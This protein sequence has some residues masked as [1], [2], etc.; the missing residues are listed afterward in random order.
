MA[1]RRCRNFERAKAIVVRR[2][3]MWKANSRLAR[4]LAGSTDIRHRE[5]KPAG[6]VVAVTGDEV[7]A[8]AVAT[9]HDAEAVVLDLV[10]AGA[11]G[12]SLRRRGQTPLDEHQPGAGA[13]TQRHNDA[14]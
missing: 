8:R 9:R 1:L 6:E 13:Q 12:R 4:G 3:I 5:R 11:R 2:A 7:D 14:G 10:N